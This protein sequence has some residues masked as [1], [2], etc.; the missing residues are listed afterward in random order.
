MKQKNRQ[1]IALATILRKE[2]R[3]NFRIWPQTLLPPV[4]TTTLYFLIFGAFIGKRIGQIQEFNYMDFIAPGL[5]MLAIINSSYSASVSSFFSA[6]FQRSIEEVLVAPV[7][8]AVILIGYM[9][10]GVIRGSLVGLIVAIIA[11]CFS[12]FEIHSYLFILLIAATSA[13]IFSL[14]GIIN[15]IFSTK[16]DDI[17]IIPTFVLTPLTYLGGVFYSLSMLPKFWYYISL[18]NPIVYIVGSFRYGFLGIRDAHSALSLLIMFFCVFVL[19]FIALRLL[20][21]GVG[22]RN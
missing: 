21:K 8:N 10:A 20:N 2:M 15:A 3:R 6:K 4:I 19:F 14:G 1:L 9:F 16:F 11:F 13:C 22:L 17:V 18:A 5:I 7:N 12:Q